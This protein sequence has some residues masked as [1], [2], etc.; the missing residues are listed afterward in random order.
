TY[1]STY[2]TSTSSE[3]GKKSYI[4]IGSSAGAAKQVPAKINNEYPFEVGVTMIPQKEANTSIANSKVISQGPSICVFKSVNPQEVVASWLLVK[5]LV[6]NAEFEA[7]Y[8]ATAGYLPVINSVNDLDGYS[9]IIE[10]ADTGANMAGMAAKLCMEYQDAFFTSPAFFGSATARDQMEIL[11]N[12]CVIVT[13][14]TDE[15]VAQAI[16]Q[17]FKNVLA[18]CEY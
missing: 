8:G 16:K 12:K 15:A 1:T 9:Q 7:R 5:F 3:E 11:L 4:S 2:F 10:N 17:Q 6:T 13:G 14:S 18:E